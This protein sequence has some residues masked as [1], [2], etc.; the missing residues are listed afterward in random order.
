MSEQSLQLLRSVFGYDSFRGQQEAI[1]QHLLAGKDALVLMPTGGGKSLCYQ[2]PAMIRPGVGVIISPLIALMQ[3]QVNALIQFGVRA[4]FLNSSLTP[5]SA[6]YV[7]QRMLRGD[8]DLV[9]VAPERL[10]TP[11]FLQLLEQTP[12]ALFAIDEAH[13]VS[14]WGH[15]FR[16]EYLQLAVLHERFSHIPRIALTA[17]ADEPTRREIIERLNLYRADIFVTGFDRP[18]IRYRVVLKQ[19]GRTQL[20]NFIKTEHPNDAGIVYCLTRARVEEVAKWLTD[21]GWNAL[22]YHA[23][24]DNLTR[25]RNQDRFINEEGVIMVATVAFGM[26]IDKP[27]VRFVAHLDLP[28]S[29]EAYYQ[30]TGRAGRDNLPANTWM[31]YSLGDVISLRQLIASSEANEQR[32]RIEQIKLNALLGY[33]ETTTCRRQ[34]LLKYFGERLAEPC[35]NCDTCLEPIESW[36][37]TI[38]AQKALSCVYRT[39]QRFGAGY[40]VD[41]LLGK[42]TERIDRFQHN[43]V[44]TFGIG[45]ELKESQWHAV[46][47]QLV[48]AG[49]LTVDVEGHGGLRLTAE[50]WPILKGQEKVQFRK[51]PEPRKKLPKS[52]KPMERSAFGD[53]ATQALWDALRARRLQLARDQGVP[54]YVIF[55]DSTL[56]EMVRYRPQRL[57]DLGTLSGVGKAKL[58]RYGKVFME[59]LE[60]HATTYGRPVDLPSIPSFRAVP[61]PVQA[62]GLSETAQATLQLFQQGLTPD[63]IATRRGFKTSTIYNHL[64]EAIEQG[65]LDVDEVISLSLQEIRRIEGVILA[66]PEEQRFTLKPVFEALQGT[67]DYEILRCVRAGMVRKKSHSTL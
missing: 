3:D 24:L 50:S 43:R 59:V 40:L 19:S 20:A 47:R 12:L 38:A 51:D 33:C 14:Q 42:S 62:V 31:A 37:G 2:I 22:P 48:A 18:N 13:C 25:K 39:G 67:Y 34:V 6:Q 49:R 7:E 27:N 28:K 36:D 17:T 54:P 46:F 53:P 45:K 23:G 30:E 29:L 55:H 64:A 11:R 16:P 65:E 60:A 10:M 61:P 9:Y 52:L 32:K 8:L 41:V 66:L 63:E 4:A 35:G 44:S 15:D 26:G 56:M 5:E 57:E 21:Q 58:E 1:I